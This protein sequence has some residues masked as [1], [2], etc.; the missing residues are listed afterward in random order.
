MPTPSEGSAGRRLAL[1]IATGSYSDPTL[2]KLHAPGQDASDL[3]AVLED[4]AVGG[5][6][7]ET[8]LDAPAD[9]LRRQ[10]ARFCA[11]GGPHDLALVYLS[12]HGVLDDRGRLYYATTDTDRE[13]LAAT[14][15]PSAWLNEQL[16]DCRCRR[17]ILVLDCCHSGAFAKGAKGESNLALRERFEGRGRVV[18]T[19][20]RATEYSFERGNVVG[21]GASSVFTGALVE[22]LRSGDADRDGD[23]AITV[24]ELY[25]YAY[26]V[27]RTSDTKQTP[28]LW[29]Y[30]AEGDLLVAQSPRGAVVEPAP[31][32]EDLVAHLESARPRVRAGAV[33]ELA[34]LL[35]GPDAGRALTARAQLDRIAAED[36][37]LVAAA[38]RAAL[39]SKAEP[40]VAAQSQH[41][42]PPSVPP[43][44]ARPPTRRGTPFPHPRVLIVVT[45][46]LVAAALTAIASLSGNA[47]K[48]STGPTGIAVSGEPRGVA[49]GE[50]A[51]W[52]TRHDAGEVTRI[53]SASDTESIDVG[54][55]PDK[56]AAGDGAV[57]VTVDDGRRLARIDPKTHKVVKRLVVDVTGCGCEIAQL[58]IAQGALWSSSGTDRSITR[59]DLSSGE[60]LQDAYEPGA[61]FQGAFAVGKDVVWAVA[62]DG[63]N[64]ATSWLIR[65]DPDSG[66]VERTDL[67][68]GPKLSGV[69]YGEGTVWMA[70]QADS[71][72]FV[73]PFN[74]RNG[75]T[76]DN[77]KVDG[78]I[79]EDDIAVATGSV[80]VWNPDIGRLTRI[81]ADQGRV[82]D[83]KP[84]RG[85]SKFHQANRAWSDLT[86]S[87]GSAWV[88][89][90]IGNA[91]YKIE[92]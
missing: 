71:R 30:G 54:D 57:W 76:G 82:V 43:P 68:S 10:V 63:R 69:A 49:V 60:E 7:V 66:N 23:G 91:V 19:G 24:T 55:N 80:L 11:Q 86:V 83:K 70:D 38:A 41:A 89:D 35:V 6:A 52:V 26:E 64:P 58:E 4:E 67:G 33:A 90:P 9:V 46:T 28:T 42:P 73:T 84:V 22:G 39:D 78:G 1:V 17:Q 61:G 79:I 12:C 92:Y 37:P 20:S 27:V 31:L 75:E 25:D 36:V 72:N 40:D 29:S 13:L 14:A 2:A 45:V 8:V 65:I 87:D 51:T 15:V 50:G 74:P 85:F 18:L 5:F 21:D 16:E 32:P 62:N 47:E 53:D 34:D 44:G 56:I 48:A 3:A 77:I 81:D 59:R 88:T